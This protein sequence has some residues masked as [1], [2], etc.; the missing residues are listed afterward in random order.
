M[1]FRKIKKKEINEKRR[2]D[3]KTSILPGPHDKGIPYS[4]GDDFDFHGNILKPKKM[5]EFDIWAKAN[6]KKQK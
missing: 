1:I 2:S 6:A 4:E 3:Q 5:K